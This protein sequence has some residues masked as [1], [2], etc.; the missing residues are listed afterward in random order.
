[1]SQVEMYTG[2][3]YPLFKYIFL[4]IVLFIFYKKIIHP[5]ADKMLELKTEE[6]EEIASHIAFEEEEYED[7]LE[8]LNEM[9]K[10]VEQQLGFSGEADEESLRY[11]VLLERLRDLAEDKTEDVANI[12]TQLMAEEVA[13]AEGALKKPSE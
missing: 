3:F 1:M 9:R 13:K 7:E 6:E 5:F 4:A 12:I 8:R 11:D 2:P 10:K